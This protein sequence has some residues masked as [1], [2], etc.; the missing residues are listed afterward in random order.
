MIVGEVAELTPYVLTVK[1]PV[2]APGATMT[3]LGK[4]TLGLELETGTSNPVHGAALVRVTV[5]V[6]EVPPCTD[7]GETDTLP[8]DSCWRDQTIPGPF[9]VAVSP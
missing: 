7:N 4:L 6:A 2:K 1:V 5:P 3:E 9:P 8:M